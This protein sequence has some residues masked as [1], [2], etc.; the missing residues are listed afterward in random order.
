[1]ELDTTE[2]SRSRVSFALVVPAGIGD[3]VADERH[4][5]ESAV[6]AFVPQ[7]AAAV[8]DIDP[9]RSTE[10]LGDLNLVHADFNFAHHLVEVEFSG[11]GRAPAHGEDSQGDGR[12][13]K[14][15]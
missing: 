2:F 7:Q 5:Q 12:I 14:S 13:K 3:P 9:G 10:D 11:G 6:G 15:H 1:M 8:D 4:H